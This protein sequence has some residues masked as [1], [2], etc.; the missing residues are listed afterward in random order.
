MYSTN[1]PGPTDCAHKD[2]AMSDAQYHHYSNTHHEINII[3][4]VITLVTQYQTMYVNS[5]TTIGLDFQET[6]MLSHITTKKGL[7]RKLRTEAVLI[8]FLGLLS[9]QLNILHTRIPS[10]L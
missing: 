8:T 9:V 2:L 1:P 7:Y 10:G 5:I 4:G 6:V 3:A